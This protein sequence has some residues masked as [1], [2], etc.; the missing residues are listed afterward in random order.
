MSPKQSRPRLIGSRLRRS[1]YYDATLRYGC[2][3]YTH[4]NHMY[5]PVVY[6]SSV[7]DYWSLVNNVTI[8]DVGC[9]RQIEI[10][11]K[12]A[13][14]FVQTLTPRNLSN[15]SVG[16]CKY[17]VLTADDGGIVSDLVLLRLGDNHFWLSIADTN[18]MLWTRGVAVHSGH[19]VQIQEPDVSPLAIQGPEAEAVATELFGDWIRE[20]RYFWFREAELDGIPLVVARSGWS[21]QGGFELYL[22]DGKRG[23]E[24]WELVVEAGKPHNIAPA[25]PSWIER[26]ESGLL[27]YGTDMTLENN[28]F[29]MGLDRFV[30]LEQEAEFIGKQALQRIQAEGIAQKLVGLEMVGEKV[31]AFEGRWPVTAEGK[32]IGYV[33]GATHSPRLE[34]NIALAMVSIA[35]TQLGTALAV[36]TPYGEAEARVVPVPFIPPRK[37]IR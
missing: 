10:R 32:P 37:Q 1:P 19:K 14:R 3:V 20:L 30:D 36:E 21:R 9:Q 18:V 12:D 11:G 34:K 22:R 24:L 6:E 2:K 13:A 27:D 33:T 23:D 25:A 4:Y 17:I 26:I 29:E 31:T 15:M 16:Q 35:S 7:A 5:L 28:P 8:W